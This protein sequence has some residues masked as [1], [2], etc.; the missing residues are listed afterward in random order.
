MSMITDL[1]GYLN[2]TDVNSVSPVKHSTN[3]KAGMDM[4]MTDYLKLMVASFQNQ[5]I[6]DV[7]STS[8]M[9]NQMVQ[10]TVV[11][12]LTNLNTLVTETNTLNYAASMV[13]KN[14]TIGQRDGD[15]YITFQGTVTGTG[16]L[17]GEQVIFLNDEVYKISDVVAIGSMPGEAAPADG[18]KTK[19]EAQQLLNTRDTTLYSQ[20]VQD[21]ADA[22]G[23]DLEVSQY[24]LDLLDRYDVGEELTQIEMDQL[25]YY[26]LDSLMTSRDAQDSD[27][28]ALSAAENAEPAVPNLGDV[29]PEGPALGESAA[30]PYTG[31]APEASAG[32]AAAETAEEG[33]VLGGEVA[34]SG[35]GEMTVEA[36]EDAASALLEE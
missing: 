12:A 27:G 30:E 28:E 2:T 15:D 31:E 17:N 18:T 9:M 20:A 1:T 22:L 32:A 5:S 36:M 24:L 23:V 25:R 34:G 13:G 8:D 11:Q 26:G 29:V 35:S 21:L 7:A 4:D 6:D 33:R 14:V 19:G 3:K 10:M 16:M